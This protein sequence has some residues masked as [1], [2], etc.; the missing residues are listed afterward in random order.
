[1]NI[2][3]I[4]SKLSTFVEHCAT[5]KIPDVMDL[6]NAYGFNLMGRD[7]YYYQDAQK[8]DPTYFNKSIVH[9]KYPSYVGKPQEGFYAQSYRV[10]ENETRYLF[11]KEECNDIR[12]QHMGNLI[13]AKFGVDSF[14]FAM[15]DCGFLVEVNELH[16]S[17]I[18]KEQLDFI[19]SRI[20]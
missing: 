11:V 6:Y 3:K 10:M 20:L 19:Y 18:D 5:Q 2:A 1:M 17:T 15:F 8:E 16:L 7:I 13:M 4:S 14:V 9:K 12:F